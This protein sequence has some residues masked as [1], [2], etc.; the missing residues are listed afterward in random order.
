MNVVALFESVRCLWFD[1]RRMRL[2]LEAEAAATLAMGDSC[3]HATR[4]ATRRH[5]TPKR[6]VR[7]DLASVVLHLSRSTYAS[8]VMSGS[9]MLQAIKVACCAITNSCYIEKLHS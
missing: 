8:Y 4:R 2:R 3:P 7:G 9:I 1:L 6:H 5:V